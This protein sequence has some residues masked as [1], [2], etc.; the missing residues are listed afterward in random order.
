MTTRDTPTVLQ[1][2]F[3]E[4]SPGSVAVRRA[5]APPVPAP[6]EA[7]VRVLACGICGTDV[8]LLHGMALPR[9]AD[10]PVRP[11]HEVAGEIVAVEGPGHEVSVGDLVVLHPLAPCE[12]CAECTSGRE[13]YCTRARVLGIHAPGG[14]SDRICWPTSRMVV[15][16]GLEPTQAAVL[17]DAVATAQRAVTLADLP[18]GGSLC[19][20]GAGGVGTHV[21]EL[22]R[23]A[24]PTATL[25]AVANSSAST[26]RLEALGF[27]ALQ[28]LDGIVR[29]LRERFDPFDVVVDFSGQDAAPARGVRLL[30]PGGTLLFGSVLGGDLN[31]G[32]ATTVQVREL[33]VKG[34]YSA[35]MDDLRQVVA[36]ARTGRLDLS[37]SVSHVADLGDAA[38]AFALLEQ[39]PP[40]LVRMVVTTGDRGKDPLI[41]HTIGID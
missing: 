4:I 41:L 18:A 40:G 31:T 5:D 16:N 34:V 39:R 24:D 26:A 20:L 33:T 22:L 27:P 11:G 37:R 38:E 8:S 1:H 29:R 23:I 28:G 21:L 12:T 25:V 13:H 10:Y 17:A 19:V 36:L 3:V 15:A 32:N 14:L 30:R 2:R 7:L 9:G 6:G 35:T